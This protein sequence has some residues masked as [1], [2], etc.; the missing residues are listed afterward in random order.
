MAKRRASPQATHNRLKRLRPNTARDTTIR[1]LARWVPARQS[2]FFTHL[3]LDVRNLI[4]DYMKPT[5]RPF[6]DGKDWAG[7]YLSCRQAQDELEDV[8][9]TQFRVY[10]DKIKAEVASKADAKLLITHTPGYKILRLRGNLPAMQVLDSLPRLAEL[11]VNDLHFTF[12]LDGT[13][14]SDQ[15]NIA[16]KHIIRKALTKVATSFDQYHQNYFGPLGPRVPSACLPPKSISIEYDLETTTRYGY[17]ADFYSLNPDY[18]DGLARRHVRVPEELR[19]PLYLELDGDDKMYSFRKLV[20]PRGATHR[21]WNFWSP[22]TRLNWLIDTHRA[23]HIGPGQFAVGMNQYLNIR[24]PS[25]KRLKQPLMLLSSQ[26]KKRMILEAV[27]GALIACVYWQWLLVMA[28][29]AVY[30]K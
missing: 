17:I 24:R 5:L 25:E 22:P 23:P 13:A 16:N 1:S 30:G 10:I 19:V 29:D 3:H 4:Y 27:F 11:F 28:E 12:K 6:G 7:L 14:L 26:M 9:A 8:A 15:A 20:L 18:L 21:M 2:T